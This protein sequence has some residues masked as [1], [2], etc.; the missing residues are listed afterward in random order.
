[1]GTNLKGCLV[2]LI[3]HGLVSLIDVF[4]IVLGFLGPRK[5]KADDTGCVVLVTGTFYAA[6]W[7]TAHIRP[8]AF[9]KKCA[10][11]LVVT[12][13]PLPPMEKVEAI[14]PPKL[15][16]KTIGS[17]PARL[18]TFFWIAIT[19]SP[20]VIGGFHLLMNGMLA[21]LIAKFIGAKS[22]YFCV[23]GPM[24]LLGGGIYSENRLFGKLEAPDERLEKK[25]IQ[26][27][28]HFDLVVTMGKKAIDFFKENGV[29]SN[30]QAISGGLDSN[31]FYPAASPP[32]FDLILVGRLA[33]I[34]RIDLF[35]HV[36]EVLRLTKRGIKAVIVGD[37]ALRA[38][39]EQ[40][41]HDLSLD[42]NIEMVG[43]QKDVEGWLR[44]SRIFVLT[45]DS[46][47]LALSLMEAMMCGL[48]AV[49]S[50]VGELSELVEQGVN[51]YLISDRSAGSFSDRILEILSDKTVYSRFSEA[52]CRSAERH[53]LAETTNKWNEIF[54]MIYC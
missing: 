28:R 4:L 54:K 50:D 23:G 13:Y 35:L 14:Y 48:P 1:M 38:K 39:L 31:R 6:N 25:L 10:R 20:H 47:G 7:A 52:A 5:K 11:V 3:I 34:K 45:S 33:P 24:E 40:T 19:R 51:G 43:H 17:V 42:K 16:V 53:D 22:I 36:V 49:V 41:I 8:L 37:G 26:L 15:L 9:S 30:F 21:A 2:R 32:D 12:T 18:L 29:E 27:V 44:R 46:E